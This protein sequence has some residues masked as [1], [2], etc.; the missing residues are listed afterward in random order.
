[1]KRI[2]YILALLVLPIILLCSCSMPGNLKDGISSVIGGLGGGGNEGGE[3]DGA[4]TVCEH[5]STY[6]RI[7]DPT[8]TKQGYRVLLCNGCEDF[9]ETEIIPALDHDLTEYEALEPTCTEDG[10]Y[11]YFTCSRCNYTNYKVNPATG[12]SFEAWTV[13]SAPTCTED[14][15][16]YSL[17]S[18]CNARSDNEAI[19]MTGHDMGAWEDVA[20]SSGALQMRKCKSCD[21]S[22]QRETPADTYSPSGEILSVKGGATSIV[23]LI[24]DDGYT[25]SIAAMDRRF[26]KYGLVGDAA[27]LVDYVIEGGNM[28]KPRAAIDAFRHY[29]SNGRWKVINHSLTHR[30]WGDDTT[31]TVSL[32]K[33]TNEVVKSGELLREL[34]PGQRV[35]TFAYPGISAL[36][37][38]FGYDNVYKEIRELVAEYYVAGRGFL[39]SGYDEIGN[40]TWD[41]TQCATLSDSSVNTILKN[42]DKAGES[43]KFYVYLAH[44]VED[45]PNHNITGENFEIICKKISELVESGTVWNTHYEDAALYLREVECAT[46]NISGNSSEIIISITDTLDDET[47]N[48]PL[49]VRVNL[50]DTYPAVKVVQGDRVTYAVARELDGKWIADVEIVPDG[51]EAVITKIAVEDI[52][53]AEPEQAADCFE[54]KDGDYTFESN[55]S[56]VNTASANLTTRLS[57]A[58]NNKTS[59]LYLIKE[60]GVASVAFYPTLKVAPISPDAFDARFSILVEED[61]TADISG[62]LATVSFADDASDSPY[63]LTIADGGTGFSLVADGEII[64]ES[65]SFGEWHKIKIIINNVNESLPYALVMVDGTTVYES[66]ATGASDAPVMTVSGVYMSFG[67]GARF[68]MYIDNLE[69]KHGECKEILSDMEKYDIDLNYFPGWTRKSVTFSLD[70]GILAEDEKV[71]NVLRPAGILGTFNLYMVNTAEAE[72]YRELYEGYGIANHCKNHANFFIESV[73]YNFTDE[74]WPGA[75]EADTTKVYRHPKVEGLYYYFITGYSWHPITDVE[76]YLRFATE[77]EA[78]IE[79]IFGEGVVKGFI[80]PNGTP[81]DSANKEQVVQYLKAHGYTNIRQTFPLADTNFSL[82]KDRFKWSLNALHTN[83]LTN[84]AAYEALEDDGELKMFSF[85]VHAKD[86]LKPDAREGGRTALENLY[87]FAATYGYRPNDYYYATVEQI[88]EY[89]DAIKAITVEDGK[90]INNSESATVYFT[91]CGERVTLAPMSAYTL[92]SGEI[93]AL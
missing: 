76:T 14:G 48:Y 51:G 27:L 57:M 66:V 9:R 25:S 50:P 20:I 77:T 67:E 3:D 89:E 29:M 35:L 42:L 7:T 81:R 4:G 21:H 41:Y 5:D 63:I 26:E 16:K 38:K 18:V 93:S 58:D 23:V 65:I 13:E 40:I 11:Y 79:E 87:I 10:H 92:E 64:A 54:D 73:E 62:T 37:N 33:M 43:G 44:G 34:F 90:V 32:S 1:M 59:S 71:L 15:V 45:G 8:C 56:G 60:L 88:F 70:D 80:Y 36:G 91:V 68:G 47:Y 72:R 22:I 24:H 84:M 19:P 86:F 12:H 53:E 55:L 17:C 82:P 28:D 46:L 30:Y 39:S 78:E 75:A 61:A 6:Y 85:G 49:S 74:P 83:L 52:P 31:L 2:V 69:L